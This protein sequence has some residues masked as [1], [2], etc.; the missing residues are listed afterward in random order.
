MSFENCFN[1][2]LVTCLF[3]GSI[4]RS[5]KMT[6]SSML[7]TELF[8]VPTPENNEALRSLHIIVIILFRKK[9]AYLPEKGKVCIIVVFRADTAWSFTWEQIF[10]SNISPLSWNVGNASVTACKTTRSQPGIPQPMYILILGE[11]QYWRL[12]LFIC[13]NSSIHHERDT[14][15]DYQTEGCT[16]EQQCC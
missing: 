5:D 15:H 7:I 8:T 4:L 16:L 14:N 12:I 3:L 1:V 13:N 2:Y 11:K 9:C 6:G 10:R